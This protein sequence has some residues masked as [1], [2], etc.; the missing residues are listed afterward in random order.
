[1]PMCKVIIFGGT[2]EGRIL[3]VYCME[4]EIPVVV[5]VATPYGARIVKREQ[6]N[7]RQETAPVNTDGRDNGFSVHAGRLGTEEMKDL[8]CHERAGLVLDATH[9]YALLATETIRT[10]CKALDIRYLRIV[11]EEETADAE[12]GTLSF[13]TIRDAVAFLS[14]EEGN[15]FAATGGSGLSLY[16]AL[17]GYRD[18]LYVRV[19]PSPQCIADALA[20]GI[21]GRHLTAMQGPFSEEMNY[22]FLKEFEIRWMVTKQSGAAGGYLEKLRAAKRAGIPLL[23]IRRRVKETGISLEEAIHCLE[24]WK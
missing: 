14:A 20:L 9:P 21:E 22:A 10:A 5:C 19:L 23:V 3:S 18:R 15:I 6:E 7:R 2:T 11:R 24:E 1:M 12:E 13:D 17:P 16:T 4:H 8:L